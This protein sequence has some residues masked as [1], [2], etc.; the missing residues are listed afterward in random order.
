MD[1][2]E[3][4]PERHMGVNMKDQQKDWLLPTRFLW[5]S[6]NMLHLGPHGTLK[7]HLREGHGF[8]FGFALSM[9]NKA[10]PCFNLDRRSH[11]GKFAQWT[12]NL[13]LRAGRTKM[14]VLLQ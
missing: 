12:C 11:P 3:R 6:T 4:L 13:E 5:F 14:E 1:R 7:H 8:P 10:V 9:S 2:L